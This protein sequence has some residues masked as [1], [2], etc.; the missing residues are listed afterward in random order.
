MKVTAGPGGVDHGRIKVGE[1]R[2]TK[3]LI[4][5]NLNYACSLASREKEKCE[6]IGS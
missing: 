5:K 2:A 1:E 4:Q 3:A 6:L